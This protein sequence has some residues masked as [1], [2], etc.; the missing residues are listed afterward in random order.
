M[1][2]K[3]DIEEGCPLSTTKY[4]NTVCVHHE[5]TDCHATATTTTS[6]PCERCAIAPA[7]I[8]RDEEML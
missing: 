2:D 1:D 8:E 7:L 6:H 3:L 4:E 5:L